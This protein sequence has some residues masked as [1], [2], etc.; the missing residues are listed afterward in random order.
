[1]HE[2]IGWY[3]L[4]CGAL[5][6]VGIATIV[7]LGNDRRVAARFKSLSSEFD[8]TCPPETT[9]EG[10][11][12]LERLCARLAYR[13]LPRREEQRQ[14]LRQLLSHAGYYSPF[15]IS[16]YVTAQ[17]TLAA[18]ALAAGAWLGA[19]KRLQLFDLC[20]TAAIAACAAYLLPT[21]WLRRRKAVRHRIL[22]RSLPDLLDLMVTCLDAGMSLDAVIQRV[23]EEIGFAHPVLSTEL[24]RVQHEIEL[25]TPVDRAMQNFAERTDSEIVRSLATVCHQSRKYG[26]RISDSLRVHSDLLRDQREQYAEEAAQKASVKILFPTLLCLFPAIFVVL[27]GPAAIQISENFSGE[28]G[29]TSPPAASARN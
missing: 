17:V 26:A 19:A 9:A 8:E 24:Q 20:L 5:G 12:L 21:W 29:Q 22:S 7:L 1:M 18:A 23:T 10:A 6:G 15:A 27:A 25:G 16:V 2:V 4:A 28:N 3:L 14:H 13:L 11:S